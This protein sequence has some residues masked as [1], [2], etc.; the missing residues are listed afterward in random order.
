MVRV[1]AAT[2]A[3]RSRRMARAA[4]AILATFVMSL[5]V[6]WIA[7]GSEPAATVKT[8]PPDPLAGRRPAPV[9]PPRSPAPA[10][11]PQRPRPFVDPAG[12]G[13]IAY[14]SGDYASALA[15]FQEAVTRNPQDAEALSNLGQIL[16]RL[17]RPG[18]AV[19]Y[20][21]RA[22]SLIPDR[23]AYR[24]NLARAFGLLGRWDESVATYREAQRLFP[25]DYVTTFN[26]ALTL[27]KKGDEAA[28]VEEYQKAVA[29]QPEDASFRM[30]LAISY[31][32]LQKPK[33]AAAAYGEYLRLSPSA[34]DADKVR[35]RI[36]QLSPQASPA[37]A[38][39]TPSAGETL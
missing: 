30:A 21:Q 19:P 12:A 24:F 23:W 32:R 28:A 9:V 29:F 35:A 20:F 27:H 25:Q 10:I 2:L 17:D 4:A 8:A 3:G 6:L 1:D 11:D 14:A 34:P 16:V 18:E 31:E 5:G 37:P 33:E 22:S 36:A 38:P 39:S 13:T 26:L 15:R 7:K